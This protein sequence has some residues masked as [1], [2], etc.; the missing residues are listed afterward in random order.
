MD[1]QS[2]AETQRKTKLL[3]IAL[4]VDAVLVLIIIVGFASLFVYIPYNQKVN[5]PKA[6]ATLKDLEN[7]FSQIIPIPGVTQLETESSHKI[8]VGGVS[9]TIKR[10]RATTRSERITTRN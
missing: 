3:S 4:V 9:A 7:E 8:S 6:D 2:A 1:M 5:G 10:V